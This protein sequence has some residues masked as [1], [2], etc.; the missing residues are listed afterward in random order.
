MENHRI[1]SL[2]IAIALILASLPLWIPNLEESSLEESSLEGSSFEGAS[3]EES[4]FD[5]PIGNFQPPVAYAGL[6]QDVEEGQVVYFNSLNSYESIYNWHQLNVNFASD[7]ALYMRTIDPLGPLNGAWEGGVMEWVTF[8]STNPFWIAKQA[9][10]LGQG[11]TGKTYTYY[12][13]M[14][15]TNL[16]NLTFTAEN[17]YYTADV[18]DETTSSSVVSGIYVNQESKNAQRQ[19]YNDHVYRLDV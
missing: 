7:S 13:K 1:F 5:P 14:H 17:G 18:Y 8:T 10:H 19:L 15:E 6:D 4:S 9:G 16:F 3:L 11:P 12:W 2:G